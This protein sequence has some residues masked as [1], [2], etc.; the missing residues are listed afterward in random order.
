VQIKLPNFDRQ[1]VIYSLTHRA[2]R[3]ADQIGLFVNPE[4]ALRRMQTV[5][6]LAGIEQ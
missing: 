5:L 3:L 2:A 1:V 4:L 6:A